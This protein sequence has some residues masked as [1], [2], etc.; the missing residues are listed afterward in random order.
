LAQDFGSF[1]RKNTGA[2]LAVKGAEVF[3][4]TG[5]KANFIRAVSQFVGFAM[6][7]WKGIGIQLGTSQELRALTLDP[8]IDSD[9]RG[10]YTVVRGSKVIAIN[11]DSPSTFEKAG[12]AGRTLIHEL[13]HDDLQGGFLTPD[14]HR[15]LDDRARSL[16]KEHGLGDGGCESIGGW[17]GTDFMAS[18]PPCQ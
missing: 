17:F 7:G 11:S 16:L 8:T 15:K 12:N 6:G 9:T 3:G 14:S 1:I 10:Y 13:L 2:S 18:Y 5:A 4:E